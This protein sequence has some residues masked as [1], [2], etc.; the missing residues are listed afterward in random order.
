[1]NPFLAR[2]DSRGFTLVELLVAIALSGIVLGTM[3]GAMTAQGRSAAY[4][5]GL[6]DAQLTSRGIGELFQQDLRMAGFG[7]LGVS[8]ADDVPPLEYS[9]Q[10]DREIVTLRGAYSNVQTNLRQGALAGSTTLVVE[11]PAAGSFST[12]EMVLVDSGMNSEIRTI[13]GTATV[14][15]ELT[16]NLDAPL[17]AQYPVGPNVTQ[18]DVIVWEL[19]GSMLTR[20]GAVIADNAQNFDL[21]YIDNL[22][23]ITDQ[24][25]EDLRAVLVDLRTA[26]PTRLPDNPEASSRLDT[27]VN[28]RNL[29][30]RFSLG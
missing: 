9:V 3:V 24:P 27:E 21:Q 15:G 18:L 2:A 11:P 14:A 28:V 20:N 29:A 10:G 26:Q 4:Q 22:G 17:A 5:Q 13:T 25:G 1:M 7:M 12:G 30:F 8:P 16:L 6:A 19:D 23:V